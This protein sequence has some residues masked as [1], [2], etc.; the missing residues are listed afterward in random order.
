MLLEQSLWNHLK[1]EFGL[2]HCCEKFS[3]DE[4][5]NTVAGW[6]AFRKDD[7]I[8]LDH[9]STNS[10]TPQFYIHSQAII[11]KLCNA[12]YNFS[13]KTLCTFEKMGPLHVVGGVGSSR[14]SVYTRLYS[15]WDWME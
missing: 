8:W 13:K 4:K 15:W 5:R 11:V 10:A 2:R 6:S 12:V 14:S 7:Y 3:S 1:T 9:A